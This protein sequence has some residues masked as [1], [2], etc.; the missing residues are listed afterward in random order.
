MDMDD[1]IHSYPVIAVIS[2]LLGASAPV[3]AKFCIDFITSKRKADLDL[4]QAQFDALN[5]ERTEIHQ[6]QQ[7]FLNDLQ[8]QIFELRDQVIALTKENF[9]YTQENAELRA[10]INI[11]TAENLELKGRIAELES[12]AAN[13]HELR[14]RVTVLDSEVRQ[15]RGEKNAPN[16]YPA[17]P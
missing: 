13:A 16:S 7:T 10:K 15:L 14:S 2:A 6:R 3:A 11:L 9:Q 5:K 12:E 4:V 17:N 1:F 8:K